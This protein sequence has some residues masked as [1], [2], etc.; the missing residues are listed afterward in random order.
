MAST[1][2]ADKVASTVMARGGVGLTAVYSSYALTGALVVN[3][4]IQM[5]KVPEN[6]TVL[7][8]ILDV[9]DLDTGTSPA[10]ALSVG[11]G[12]S[13]TRYLSSA[14]TG[15]SGGIARIT[16]AGSSQ[17]NYSAADTIDIKVS[18]GPS[19]GA[20]TGTL[21]LAVLYTMQG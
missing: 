13:A 12:D 15:Q 5:C 6:A 17:T 8:I 21:K 1:Y 18:T 14:T 2:Y 4:V 19:T 11:D 3:D 7:D 20:T 10:I 16:V 9:P